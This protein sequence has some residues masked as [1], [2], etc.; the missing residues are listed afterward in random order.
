MVGPL[1]REVRYASCLQTLLETFHANL[2]GLWRGNFVLQ[3]GGPHR[4][5]EMTRSEDLVVDN[6]RGGLVPSQV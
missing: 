2:A 1:L 6:E 3:D 5:R 4:L